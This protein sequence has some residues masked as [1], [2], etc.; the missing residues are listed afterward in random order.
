[1]PRYDPTEHPLL[2]PEA[3]RLEPEE[4]EAQ[5]DVAEELLGLVDSRHTGEKADRATRA[6]ALQVNHQVALGSEASAI[7]SKGRGSRSVTY[8]QTGGGDL[9]S[10]S[11]AARKIV[12]QLSGTVW[13]GAGSLR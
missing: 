1:M 5:A 10:V 11:A 4:L 12:E 8:R 2:S 6:V 3:A 7:Q 13:N 9:V